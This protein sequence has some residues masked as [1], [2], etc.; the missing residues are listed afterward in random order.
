MAGRGNEMDGKE[1]LEATGARYR[2][3]ILKD[4]RAGD[5][6][7]RGRA[8]FLEEV[9]RLNASASVRRPSARR[10]RRWLAVVFPAAVAAATPMAYSIWILRDAVRVQ[11]DER[12]E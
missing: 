11:R 2:E 1:D 12:G 10:H 6:L 4:P 3:L 8:A 5:E 7:R 9:E